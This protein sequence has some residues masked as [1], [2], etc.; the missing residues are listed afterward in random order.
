MAAGAVDRVEL[1]VVVS[2]RNGASTIANQ[3]DALA[4][5]R[6][7]GTWEVIVSDNGSTDGTSAVVERYRGRL[8][9]LRIVDASSR[10]GPAHSRNVGA[11]AA[12]GEAIAYC[13]HDDEVG[14]GWLAAMGDAL[15]RHELVAGRLD[16]DRLNEPWAIE[17]RGRPQTDRLP[18]W[19][20]G[21]YFPFAF[22]CTIGVTRRLHDSIGGFDEAMVPAAED[23][24]YCWRLQ[25]AGAEIRFVPAALTHF[26]LRH[27]LPAIYRQAR[28]Y[29][30]GNVLV[31]KKHRPLGMP[32]A[33]NP[34]A[35]GL[36]KW[37]GLP[38]HFVLAWN[39]TRFGHA[40][41]HL[42]LRTGMLQGSVQHRVLFF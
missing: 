14:D 7:E 17:V 13:D 1:S 40:V 38:K 31:Y 5:Q 16:H 39:R 21:R 11:A 28:G 20:F 18:E 35:T 25:L 24:D 27:E 2:V 10:T 34:L 15:G 23:M 6:W 41:W 32:R 3:L 36:R 12:A 19:S 4:K 33:R 22:A 29:G 8:P 30:V 42:G 26:R 9:N 37:V